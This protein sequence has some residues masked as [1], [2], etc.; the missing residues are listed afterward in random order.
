MKYNFKEKKLLIEIY[1]LKKE[2][3]KHREFS[4]SS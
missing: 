3:T 4:H 1:V 2:N